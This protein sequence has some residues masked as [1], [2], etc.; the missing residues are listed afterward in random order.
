MIQQAAAIPQPSMTSSVPASTAVYPQA[1]A[2]NAPPSYPTASAPSPEAAYQ[3]APPQGNPWQ[4]AY[5]RLAES[6]SATRPSPQQA[7]YSAPTQQ[8]AP[9]P[10]AYAPQTISYQSA[11][12]VSGMP[13]SPYPQTQGYSPAMV[14]QAPSWSSGASESVSDAYLSSVSGE[15]LEV[16]NHFGAEAP[17]LLN[18]YSCVVEDAL[19]AQAQQTAEVLQQVESLGQSMEAARLVIEAAAEDN[20]AYHLMLTDAELLSDYVNDY[21]GPNGPYPVETSE[22]RLAADVYAS[23]SRYQQPAAYERPQLEM[24]EPGYQSAGADDF[25]SVFSSISDRNP[26]AA[27][28]LLSQATP[29]ALRSK[30]LISEA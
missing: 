3:P 9:I 15:S 11:P 24:P 17:A 25:W 7:S 13:I 5:N 10:T 21:F 8:V 14:Q 26:Q 4:E 28:Q 12:S 6:L 22:D 18:R 23:E 19:L 16:L 20:A 30:L 29:E 27:W 2:Q 1:Q